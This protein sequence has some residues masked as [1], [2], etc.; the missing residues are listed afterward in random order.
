LESQNSSVRFP[1][2]ISES[3]ETPRQLGGAWQ[4]RWRINTGGA[5]LSGEMLAD[6]PCSGVVE[7]GEVSPV[8]SREIDGILRKIL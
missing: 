2:E 1:W 5:E 7:W 6:Q 8:F 3:H 4:R